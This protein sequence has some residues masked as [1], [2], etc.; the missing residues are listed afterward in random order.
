MTLIY[1][2]K[3]TFAYLFCHL[4]IDFHHRGVESGIDHGVLGSIG[5]LLRCAHEWFHKIWIYGVGDIE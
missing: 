2:Q 4:A 1:I 5:K 3:H